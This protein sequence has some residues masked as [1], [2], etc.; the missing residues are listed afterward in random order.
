MSHLPVSTVS[1]TSPS[2]QHVPPPCRH[3]MSHLHATTACPIFPSAPQFPPFR[4]RSKS[5]V[6]VSTERA[7]SRKRRT[8]HL[9]QA[10]HGQTSCQHS[11]PH[12]PASAACPTF[13]P[14]PEAPSFHKR[15]QSHFVLKTA[16]PPCVHNMPQ[17]PFSMIK[18]SMPHL[19]SA[20]HV[21][22]PKRGKAQ[23]VRPLRQHGMSHLPIR[24]HCSAGGNK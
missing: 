18:Y 12:Y 17:L 6:P 20:Q 9:P 4:E 22:F 14:R 8:S 13:P 3:S 1:P 5:N 16:C 10:Q 21:L 7:T 24:S 2:A 11:M 15:S 23:Q 19:L